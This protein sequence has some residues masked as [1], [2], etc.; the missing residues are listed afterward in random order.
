M[1]GVSHTQTETADEARK[2]MFATESKPLA[3]I[4]PTSSALYEHIVRSTH[5]AGHIWGCANKEVWHDVPEAKNFG[6]KL[7]EGS[8]IPFWTKLPQIWE[9]CRELDRCAC[10]SQ[11][12]T[13]R[14]ICN[15]NMIPCTLSCRKCKGNV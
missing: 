2:Q 8:W 5:Q 11:C 4:P 13:M 15:K 6:W 12:D 14:C 10:L 3:L 9:A 7:H 1:Y